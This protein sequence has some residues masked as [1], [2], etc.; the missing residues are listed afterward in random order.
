MRRVPTTIATLLAATTLL[1]GCGSSMSPTGNTFQSGVNDKHPMTTQVIG[2]VAKPELNGKGAPLGTHHIA[3]LLEVRNGFEDRPIEASSWRQPVF[4]DDSVNEQL[5]VCP[6]R[7]FGSEPT[8]CE[9]RVDNWKRKDVMILSASDVDERPRALS[10]RRGGVKNLAPG[11]PYYALVHRKF[12]ETV[13]PEQLAVCSKEAKS[14]SA[15]CTSLS[16]VPEMPAKIAE[17][18]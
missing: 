10:N 4:F 16:E 17:A 15:D 7:L 9:K 13:T 5:A 1:A 2:Y 18:L 14:K 8:S 11:E 6:A 3:V 12:D